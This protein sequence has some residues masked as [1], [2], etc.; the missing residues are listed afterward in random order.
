MRLIWQIKK[1]IICSNNIQIFHISNSLTSIA[2]LKQFWTLSPSTIST[3][4]R[5]LYFHCLPDRIFGLEKGVECEINSCEWLSRDLLGLGSH[6]FFF[7]S[8]IKSKLLKSYFIFFVALGRHY[9]FEAFCVLRKRDLLIFEDQINGHISLT[10][11]I[12][13]EKKP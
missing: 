13:L 5:S 4:L 7:P 3:I 2:S 6:L 1:N 9:L 10:S 12:I 11:F 8:Q